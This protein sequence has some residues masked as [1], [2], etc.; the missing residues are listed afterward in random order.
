MSKSKRKIIDE[1]FDSCHL[2]SFTV[3]FRKMLYRSILFSIKVYTINL[4]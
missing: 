1:L 4:Y 3:H 2:L